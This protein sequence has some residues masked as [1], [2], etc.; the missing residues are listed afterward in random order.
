MLAGDERSAWPKGV[1]N[2]PRVTSLWDGERIAG[3]W[4][5]EH[6]TGGFGGPGSIVWDAY[7]AYGLGVRWKSIPTQPIVAG[8]DIIANTNGLRSQFIP[9]L[10]S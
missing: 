2:D 5:A 6:D 4:F 8:S 7:L 1:F 9:I 3:K 10:R